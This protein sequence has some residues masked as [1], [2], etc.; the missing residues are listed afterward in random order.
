V[1]RTVLRDPCTL[2]SSIAGSRN[3]CPGLWWTSE[4][5]ISALSPLACSEVGI[6]DILERQRLGDYVWKA[7]TLYV[8]HGVKLEMVSLYPSTSV[9]GINT[10]SLWLCTFRCDAHGNK[11]G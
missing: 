3:G 1:S 11:L 4:A 5:A 10:A 6:R 2:V 9:H 7:K 8:G